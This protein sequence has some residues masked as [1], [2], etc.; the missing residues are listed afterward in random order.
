VLV[1]P[2]LGDGRLVVARQYR[3]A[4]ER[5]MIEFPAGKCEPGEAALETARRELREETGYIAARW[6]PLGRVHSVVAYSTESIEFF[7]A[8]ELT[9]VGAELDAGEFIDVA[10][11]SVED[12]LAAIEAGQITDAKTVAAL[13]LYARA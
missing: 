3:Y 4:L 5:I 12:M 7:V 13:L 8:E 2:V 1:V 10:L 9:H 6:R 11:M